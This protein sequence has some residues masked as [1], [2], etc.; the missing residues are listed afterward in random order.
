MAAKT[1]TRTQK[2]TLNKEEKLLLLKKNR[3]KS[4]DNNIYALCIC[5]AG[6]KCVLFNI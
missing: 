5:I 6:E 4:N 3:I 1:E 2:P